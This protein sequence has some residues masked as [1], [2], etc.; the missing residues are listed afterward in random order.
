MTSKL[1]AL[2]RHEALAVE[3]RQLRAL[4]RSMVPPAK[5]SPLATKLRQPTLD[6]L[7][8]AGAQPALPTGDRPLVR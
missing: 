1:S 8:P 3:R 4:G 5:P 7:A 6:V 2:S